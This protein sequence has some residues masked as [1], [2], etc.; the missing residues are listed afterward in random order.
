LKVL[1][2]N[3]Y[4]SDHGK[5]AFFRNF[6]NAQVEQGLDISVYVPVD[7]Y[8]DT[9]MQEK[10]GGYSI[11]AKTHKPLD[12]WF[13]PVKQ[14]KIL[15]D[16]KNRFSKGRFDLIHSHS[17]F[18]NGYVAWKL[19]EVLGVPFVTAVRN[20]DISYFFRYMP[21]LRKT[22]LGIL[23]KA[24]RI[25]FIS[26]P[27]LE[28]LAGRYLPENLRTQFLEKAEVIGNGIDG[29]WLKNRVERRRKPEGKNLNLLTVGKII[30]RK[31]HL[32][33]ARAAEF[34]IKRGFSVNLTVV[35]EE[36]DER[37]LRKLREYPFVR[38]LSPVPKEELLEIYREADIFVLP[39]ITET[40][41]LVYPEAMSQG[42][43]VIYSRGQGFD[44]QFEE[45]TVGFHTESK[46]AEEIA[47]RIV[48]I[49]RNYANIS[50]NCVEMCKRFNWT[51]IA[52][53]YDRVYEK[54]LTT[55][56]EG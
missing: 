21:H 3:S 49:T 31:N 9:T 34:L 39:S 56:E 30:S 18:T 1:H 5:P 53:E 48:D 2:I 38:Y 52:G 40:F 29:Y 54:I 43:P 4:Y 15:R 32:T 11:L 19:S 37:I 47:D 33:T 8:I 45:G 7:H 50:R 55:R 23:L 51:D 28:T 26:K 44:G 14:G 24:D 27:H 13:Y 6:F 16:A 42:L 17:L 12:R 25:I 41:G 22:G 46:N 35:G 20:T 10:F 36:Q